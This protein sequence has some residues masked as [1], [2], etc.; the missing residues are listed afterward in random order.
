VLEFTAC[1]QAVPPPGESFQKEPRRQLVRVILNPYGI[2][3]SMGLTGVGTSRANPSPMTLEDY[4]RLAEGYGVG[5]VEI[6]TPFLDSF[7]AMALARLKE[8][9]AGRIVVMSQPLWSGIS[10]SVACARALGAQIIRMHLTMVLCGDRAAPECRWD[11]TVSDVR[12]MLKEAAPLAAEYGLVLAIEDHQDFTSEELMEL[13][14]STAA[15]VGICLDTGNALS[16]G[17]D[18][19]DFARAVA[20][21]VRHVHL[22]D[23]RAHFTDEGYRLVRCAIGDG[24]V[25]FKEVL[26]EL[27]R[28]E[29]LAAAIEPGALTARHIRLF[30]E[31]W[32]EGYRPRSAVALARG[33][34]AARVRRMG[35]DEEWRTPWELGG[36]PKAIVEY[37]MGQMNRSV[38]NVRAMGLL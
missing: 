38:E 10:R 8:R 30:N 9:L 7:D 24:A 34:K 13:C 2:A 17:E 23:Y 3:Y 32:W 29:V 31:E 36:D 14:E 11:E 21:R 5:G 12:R 16:V 33:L 25:P 18:P 22:K 35:E 19:V 1:K 20:P 27:E 26:K 4:L 6:Y 28:A 37:E 15:N